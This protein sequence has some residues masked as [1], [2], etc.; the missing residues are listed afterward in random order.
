LIQKKGCERAAR[1]KVLAM[2]LPLL[3]KN[4]LSCLFVGGGQVASRKIE[5]LLEMPCDITIVAPYLSGLA[6]E[7]VRKGSVHWLEREYARGDCKGFQLIVAATPIREVNRR[8]SEEAREH[9]IPINVVDDPVLSTVI[10]PAVWRDKSLSVAVST[11]G[12][13]PFMAAEIRTF[14]ASCAQGMGRWVEIA[15]RFREIVRNDI[16]DANER[17]RLYRRFLEA[18]QPEETDTPPTSADLNEW[19]SWLDSIGMRKNADSCR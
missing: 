15:G 4:K 18:G 16:K 11:E 1:T 3:F 14:L 2:Y 6:A 7:E 8:V 12:S 5:T 19:L 10:F 9:G 17:K 13:A